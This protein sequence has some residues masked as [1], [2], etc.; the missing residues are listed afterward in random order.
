MKKIFISTIIL[1]SVS[2]FVSCENEGEERPDDSTITTDVTPPTI[3]LP[4]DSATVVIDLGDKDAAMAGV[5][6]KDTK[7]GNLTS[8]ITLNGDLDAIGATKLEYVVFDAA[9]NKAS[10]KRDVIIGSKKLAKKYKV[11]V[12]SGYTMTVTEKNTVNLLFSGF[13]F[14]ENATCVPDGKGKLRIQE[15]QGGDVASSDI[16]IYNGNAQYDRVGDTYNITHLTYYRKDL[17]T[18][19]IDTISEA[20][21]PL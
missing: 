1:A 12:G 2:L 6:A 13:D 4:T 17:A 16:F 5:T 10:V 21:N 19:K 18:N 15:F 3:Q 8:S 11:M 7:D 9:G 14:V 20:C